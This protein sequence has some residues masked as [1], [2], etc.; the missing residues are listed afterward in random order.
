MTTTL[1][2]PDRL[3]L[4]AHAEIARDDFREYCR[5]VHEIELPRHTLEW[6]KIYTSTLPEDR[7]VCIAAPPETWKSRFNRMYLE[8]AIGRNPEECHI[9]AMNAIAQASRQVQAI[10]ST[11]EDN[12]RYK[13]VF[14]EIEPWKTKGWNKNDFFVR[15]KAISRPDATLTGT[16]IDGPVQGLHVE[17]ITVDD[18]TDQ[19]DVRSPSAMRAQEDWVKGVLY[20]RLIRE[21]G[22]P[23][24]SWKVLLTRWGQ[25]DLWPLFTNRP[26]DEEKKGL[27][28]KAV[29]MPVQRRDPP[30]P[31]GEY[32][33]PEKYPAEVCEQLRVAKGALFTLTFMCDPG[34]LGGMVF[35]VARF[36]R[37]EL[38]NPPRFWHKVLS[39][40]PAAGDSF[41]AS[42][43]VLTELQT[44]P[45]G[46][47]LTHNWRG[48]PAYTDLKSMIYR[49][50][51]QRR[52]NIILIEERGPGTSLIRDLRSEANMPELRAID[53]ISGRKDS[54]DTGGDKY[55][56]ALRHTGLL[57]TGQLW[58]PRQ[59]SWLDEWLDEIR[60]FPNSRFSD[61]VDAYT[62]GL[63]Y[64]RGMGSRTRSSASV[65]DY[66]GARMPQR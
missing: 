12:P 30:Y 55:L 54:K 33:M 57:D 5:F 40:D 16:G 63:D 50:R 34:A 20:D 24:G 65:V 35:N 3:R 45:Q 18:P 46:Y 64:A 10:E 15:R 43:S 4:L 17:H 66:M 21:Q 47:Y 37:F 31:W 32:L 2:Q 53:P 28:F 14:P 11:I 52:P 7:N 13:M 42:Y 6:A 38:P 41:D 22:I 26:D 9:L 61:Q 56:R 19:G 58:I 25:N 1:E 51:D 59:A 48:R 23:V 27:G 62:Q 8:W 39:V 29:E 36:N 44:G 49:M 60:A